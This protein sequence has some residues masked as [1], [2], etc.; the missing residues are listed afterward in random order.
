M[1]E[2]ALGKEA[3]NVPG[4][5]EKPS[6]DV[7]PKKRKIMRKVKKHGRRK[8][9]R[10]IGSSMIRSTRLMTTSVRMGRILPEA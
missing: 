9:K 5:S 2:L 6:A 1:K 8:K 4:G 3:K 10:M 7:T